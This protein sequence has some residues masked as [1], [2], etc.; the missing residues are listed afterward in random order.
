MFTA[1]ERKLPKSE[2]QYK[3]LD[4]DQRKPTGNISIGVWQG[5]TGALP[6]DLNCGAR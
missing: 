1:T 4:P 2:V 3:L 5:G 6:Q